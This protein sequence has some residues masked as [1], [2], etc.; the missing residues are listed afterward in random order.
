MFSPDYG[1]QARITSHDFGNAPPP[2]PDA[3]RVLA[4]L[5]AALLILFFCFLFAASPSGPSGVHPAK[6]AES[7]RCLD[8]PLDAPARAAV[9]HP[10]PDV[11]HGL[12]HLGFGPGCPLCVLGGD[13]PLYPVI[14]TVTGSLPVWGHALST[15]S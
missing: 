11:P 6:A 3:L 12:L 2:L 9:A 1:S 4:S 5:L 7:P 15:L 13:F 14:A 10:R 8:T